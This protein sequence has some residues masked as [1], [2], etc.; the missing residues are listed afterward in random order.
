[1]YLKF[2]VLSFLWKLDFNI[3]FNAEFVKGSFKVFFSLSFF[4][5]SNGEEKMID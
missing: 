3:I 2:K 5:C 1:M 4:L